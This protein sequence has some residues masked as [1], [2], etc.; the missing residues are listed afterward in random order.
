M[1]RR[2]G[3]RPVV[4]VLAGAV[5]VFGFAPFYA[6]PATLL[7]LAVGFFL[8]ATASN[9]RAAAATGW[10]YGFGY[11]CASV[12]WLFIALH[13]YGGMPAALAGFCIAGFAA[14]LAL[15]P[16]LAGWLAHRSCR[17]PLWRL[18][19]ALPAA[20]ALTEWLR[21]WLFTGFPWAAAGYS[22]IPDGPL[23]GYA[24]LLGIYGVGLLLAVLAGVLAWLADLVWRERAVSGRPGLALGATVLLL[25]ASPRLLGE[26]SWTTPV[27]RPLRVALLQGAIPQDMKWSAELLRFNL[28]TYLDQVRAAQGDLLVLPETALPI[29]LQELPPDYLAELVDL[30][31][32]KGAALIVGAPR[33]EEGIRYYN[34]A[35]L[36]SDPDRPSYDK[37][38]LV[39]FG[40]YIPLRG[41]IGWVYNGLLNIPLADFTAGGPSQMPFHVGEQRIAANIC[42]ED[43][44]GAELLPGARQATMLLNLSNLAWYDH[45]VALAQHGQIAQARALETGRSMLRA[46]NTGT[47]A[48]IGPDGRYR[49]RLP[50]RVQAVL[51]ATVQGYRGETPYM[52]WGNQPFVW[53][54]CG[55]WVLA[56]WG[57]RRKAQMEK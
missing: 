17:Q 45:S 8:M 57:G 3:T 36:L 27:G 11:F 54:A 20:W 44:F 12:H 51:S 55:I 39:P 41:L 13:R 16:A 28:V 46:T 32:R 29:F 31:R 15:Y 48:V 14:F 26:I 6:W 1:R 2:L 9:G 43:V 7:S 30:S 35:V 24:P 40:E 21:G 33:Q 23:A 19:L 37:A 49:A 56:L 50:E 25:L 42:Y 4:A 5:A 22:Q 52:G 53:L 47:T 38:H 18:T 10:L 34:S